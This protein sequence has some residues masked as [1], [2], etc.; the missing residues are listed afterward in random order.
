MRLV[1]HHVIHTPTPPLYV[2]YCTRDTLKNFQ[3]LTK[4]K[5]CSI[6]INLKIQI[7]IDNYTSH[8]I[9]VF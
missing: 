6:A 9:L 7:I 5:Y 4:K 1:D 8:N 2:L 3:P